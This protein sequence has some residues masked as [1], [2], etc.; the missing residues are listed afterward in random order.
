[1]KALFQKYWFLFALVTLL[2]AG[3]F[4]S[5]SLEWLADLAWLKWSI[6]FVTMFLMAW[7]LSF[8]Q[9]KSSL[10]QPWPA[11]LATIL[12]IGIIPILAWPFAGFAGPELGPGILI[13]AATPGTLASAAV[14]TRRAG[15]NDGVA[16]MVTII[17]NASCFFV[18]PFWIFVQTGDQIDATLLTA[19]INKLLL[20]VVLPMGLG[21]L[22]RLHRATGTWATANKPKLSLAALVGLLSIVFMG[23]I[24]MGVRFSG[25]DQAGI[26]FVSLLITFLI[27]AG[28]HV[29]VFWFG[30]WI[31]K[32]L[33]FDR[34]DQ[35]AVGFSGSQKTLMI[36]LTT[37]ITLGFS[38]IPI[39]MY[40]TTQ[41]LIDAV[42]AERIRASQSAK[43]QL[44]KT[45]SGE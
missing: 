17:T 6:I 2:L 36:G 31:A 18:L 42:F 37:S 25:D 13:A 12:N 32:R 16:V 45:P 8:D 7:P 24:K 33:G 27:V 4:T 28:I 10:T 1:M 40:H 38:M 29:M 3:Y 14:W 21:Q 23:A 9:I 39:V 44:E 22:V 15:G 30:I 20:F 5:G 19:T 41:L 43:H 26:S 34:E 35:I 11:F